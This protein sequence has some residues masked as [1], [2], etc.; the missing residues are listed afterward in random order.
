MV[1]QK[2]VS[3]LYSYDPNTGHMTWK[4]SRGNAAVG[5][6][7][8]TRNKQKGYRHLRV[9]SKFYL[10]HRII[11][12]LI[13]GHL[14]TDCID[15]INGIKD[16]NRLCNLR[17]ATQQQNT[18]NQCISVNNTS[19]FKGVNSRNGRYH[20]RIQFNGKR[21][22]LGTFTTKEEAHLAYCEASIKHH[23]EFSRT[24]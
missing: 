16:D 22:I 3:K 10:E 12:L 8:G 6:R 20:A 23:K 7:A 19:G 24:N 1:T 11:W 2:M 14:P 4:V 18:Y 5:Y 21:K 17:E 13:H 9:E 15:H